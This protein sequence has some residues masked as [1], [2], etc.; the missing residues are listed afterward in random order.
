MGYG[1]RPLAPGQT[2]KTRVYNAP[3]DFDGVVIRFAAEDRA[4]MQDAP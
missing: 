2:E 1:G 3:W 4:A